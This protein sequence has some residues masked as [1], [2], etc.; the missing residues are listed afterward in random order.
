[1]RAVIMKLIK[2]SPKFKSLLRVKLN[3]LFLISLSTAFIFA[4]VEMRHA[5]AANA[6]FFSDFKTYLAQTLVP[7]L[8]A[9]GAGAL[10]PPV[11]GLL[12]LIPWLAV[13]VFLGIMIWAGVQG[14]KDIDQQDFGA[15]GG[16][17]G[18]SLAGL[19]IILILDKIS[20]FATT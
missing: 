20:S 8:G 14:Y 2:L 3:R 12:E 13:V 16:T 11:Q 17:I 10:A 1:M 19:A 5:K 6:L 18:K 7:Y 9:V 15:L 4:N